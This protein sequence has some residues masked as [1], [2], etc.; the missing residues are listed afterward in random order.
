MIW[1]DIILGIIK[2]IKGLV[3]TFAKK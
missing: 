2:L 3:D 1:T